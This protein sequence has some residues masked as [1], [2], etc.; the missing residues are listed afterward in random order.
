MPDV[1][2]I[3][4]TGRLPFFTVLRFE[5]TF[6]R[7]NFE[8]KPKSRRNSDTNRTVSAINSRLLSLRPRESLPR[9]YAQSCGAVVKE[10]SENDASIAV[11]VFVENVDDLLSVTLDGQY[12][13]WADQQFD[14]S[15]MSMHVTGFG[16]QFEA[17]SGVSAA[18]QQASN[19]DGT[20]CTT[21]TKTEEVSGYNTQAWAEFDVDICSHAE[22]H[23][24]LRKR[25][26]SLLSN[27]GSQS[28]RSVVP[29]KQKKSTLVT[30]VNHQSTLGQS[31]FS[32]LWHS[33]GSLWA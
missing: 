26:R 15:D 22:S 8:A 2:S 30:E 17:V 32:T 27:N 13:I 5:N 23:H 25:R 18:Q 3:L 24:N 7:V 4:T 10:K 11:N 14:S 1:L 21:A 31:F 28:S 16:S 12:D 29:K 19:V 9:P 6:E 33:L 20:S